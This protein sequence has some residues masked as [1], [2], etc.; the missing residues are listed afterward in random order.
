MDLQINNLSGVSLHTLSECLNL[1]FAD[2]VVPLYVSPSNLV[3]KIKRENIQLDW[4]VGLFDGKELVG[5][6][7]HGL[8]EKEG[9]KVLYN[10][11][12]GILPKYR[13]SAYTRRM[14]EFL[15]PRIR[16][17]NI[18]AVWLEVIEH[19]ERALT[20]YRKMGFEKIRELECFRGEA[21]GKRKDPRQPRLQ[22]EETGEPIWEELSTFFDYPPSWQN[23]LPALR[24][25]L[26]GSKAFTVRQGR[27]YLG[28]LLYSEYNRRLICLAIHP[29]YRRL[30]V[31][32]ALLRQLPAGQWS[33]INIDRR[34]SSL[35]AFLKNMGWKRT[36]SQMEMKWSVANIH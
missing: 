6:I 9:E 11:G 8:G 1:A 16:Q 26:S 2:Y 29:A 22:I 14:Y 12:T 13:G 3:R 19:N 23:D 18:Q 35:I 15:H 25:D 30:G 36:F 28:Y 10:G 27:Q 20:V 31:G 32:K 24:N 7:L 21:P 5:F 4:S 17:E 33:V 34:N